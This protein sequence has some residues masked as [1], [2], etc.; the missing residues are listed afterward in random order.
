MIDMQENQSNHIS[1]SLQELKQSIYALTDMINHLPSN[2]KKNPTIDTLQELLNSLNE[3]ADNLLTDI[4]QKP[5]EKISKELQENT[6]SK[7]LQHKVEIPEKAQIKQLIKD[8][9][10]SILSSLKTISTLFRKLVNIIKQETVNLPKNKWNQLKQNIETRK[11]NK[12]KVVVM[13]E[14]KIQ[15]VYLSQ[16]LDAVQRANEL[17]VALDKKE[18]KPMNKKSLLEHLKANQAIIEK[19]IEKTEK[20][21]EASRT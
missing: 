4:Q 15:T 3:V 7:D 11:Y 19:P 12:A 16:A 14:L 2:N 10:S 5:K 8:N 17:L 13:N 9:V 6:S 1:D 18:I 20:T 21:K